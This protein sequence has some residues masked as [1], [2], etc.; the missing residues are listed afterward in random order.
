MAYKA[1]Y[2]IYRP[3]TFD[4]VVGQKYIVK[5]LQNAIKNDKIAHA[6][7]FT[8]PRGTG[9]TT[10]ARL[11]AKALNCTSTDREVPCNECANCLDIMNGTHP[12][13]IEID[14]ASNNGVDDARLLVE[15]VKYAPIEGKYKVYIIDE[16]H[17]M[18]EKAFAA[19]LKTIEEPPAHVV[20]I[21][22]TTDVQ[23]VIGTIISRCQRFDFGKVSNADIHKKI[24]EIL[25]K[26]KATYD[27]ESVDLITELAE[28]GVRDAISILD[29]ALAYG[30]GVLTAQNI[31]EIYGVV[32]N[33][34]AIEFI[35][36][37]TKKDVQ[38]CLKKTDDFDK[39]GLDLARFTNTLINIIKEAV[40]YKNT[41]GFK[42]KLSREQLTNLC[43]ALSNKQAFKYIDILMATVADYHYVAS[44]RSYFEL[45]ILKMCDVES[46]T[47]KSIENPIEIKETTVVAAPSV[48]VVKVAEVKEEQPIEAVPPKVEEVVVEEV[49]VE[50]LVQEEVK[51]IEQ[52]KPVEEV[53]PEPVQVQ[54]PA[55][56]P[57]IEEAKGEIEV[58]I[59]PE[60]GVMKIAMTE[61]VV[62]YEEKDLLNV[63][64]QATN[65]D[66][67]FAK[68]RWKIIGQ[69]MS[70]AKFAKAVGLI[71]DSAVLAASSN[72]LVLGYLDPPQ[73]KLAMK[74]DSYAEIKNF[75]RELLG[76]DVAIFALLDEDFRRAKLTYIDLKAR[77]QLPVAHPISDPR[78]KEVEAGTIPVAEET[79]EEPKETNT[80]EDISQYGKTLFG[81]LFKDG[82]K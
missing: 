34:E 73:L 1:L 59:K 30:D 76:K 53:K 35:H 44:P 11:L 31:R 40:V 54:A 57:V 82:D 50:T 16:V 45:A 41:T 33:Q 47:D 10:I 79:K 81:D 61:K 18:S 20:F 49:K 32:S 12:D 58:S 15:N 72:G 26:E 38:T 22:A 64:V 43:Y 4:E 68:G 65:F 2:R 3:Q 17:M 7:L 27:E 28:G 63:M 48:E 23:K 67:D 36:D 8:G 42:G 14:A 37:I 74:A 51:P 78:V 56:Q 69:Y 75:L 25:D 60:E 6:Y 52:P 71:I 21:F 62:A 39:R 9:K 24:C 70:N 19:L 46:Q 5:T 77:G 66:R 29:Q 80:T 13:V 55:P